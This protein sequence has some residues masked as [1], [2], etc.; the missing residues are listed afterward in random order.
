MGSSNLQIEMDNVGQSF[1]IK[2]SASQLYSRATLCKNKSAATQSVSCKKKA[3]ASMRFT[4]A[5]KPPA[6]TKTVSGKK[7]AGSG[8]KISHATSS[9][10]PSQSLDSGNPEIQVSIM[11][12]SSLQIKFDNFDHS[13]EIL[14][15]SSNLSS[16]GA[17]MGSS[18]FSQSISFKKK[19][20]TMHAS[21]PP[22]STKTVSGKKAAG[23]GSKNIPRTSSSKPSLSLDSGSF[24]IRES[25]IGSSTFQIKFDNFDYCSETLLCSFKL[26]SSGT[27]MSSSLFSQSVSFKKKSDSI[28][29]SKQP[30]AAK[31]AT[32]KKVVGSGSK[33]SHATS[34][35]KP[36]LLLDS[37][38]SKIQE[39][40]MCSF[41]LQIKFDNF[42]QSYETLLSS[43]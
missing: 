19:A 43:F 27:L 22:A 18:L 28:H 20:D 38:N 30:A 5:T 29:A 37:G 42:Y 39:S 6:A 31:T 26:S 3:D 21:K 7:A 41:N 12:S 8:S 13:S 4:D 17:L 35:S 15:S 10:K 40:I 36:S 9:S 25:I 34:S 16:P 24:K 11:C 2:F 23:S 32:G 14:L 1:G 33:R